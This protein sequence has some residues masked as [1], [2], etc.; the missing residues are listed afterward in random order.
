MEAEG[1][2]QLNMAKYIVLHMAYHCFYC[3]YTWI[4]MGQ[5]DL[6]NRLIDCNIR[7][8]DIRYTIENDTVPVFYYYCILSEYFS[9]V[10]LCLALVF[11]S[12]FTWATISVIDNLL[13]LT[14]QNVLLYGHLLICLFLCL[15]LYHHSPLSLC[16]SFI[17]HYLKQLS[18]TYYRLLCSVFA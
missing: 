13:S 10:I 5:C 6:L 1:Y 9:S 8:K 12:L 17:D 2:V 14:L 11:L 7:G 18:I 15:F 4:M 3:D 16:L